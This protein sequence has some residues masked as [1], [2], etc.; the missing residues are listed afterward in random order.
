[1]TT[2]FDEL[3]PASPTDRAQVWI[4]G[5][6]DQVIDL[7]DELYAKKITED[8]AKYIPI[9]PAPFAGN[10]YMTVLVQ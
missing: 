5:S 7:L 6:R 8:R 10:K 2:E 3:L 4:I 9:I 1:M